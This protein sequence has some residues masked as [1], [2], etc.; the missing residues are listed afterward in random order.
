MLRCSSLVDSMVSCRNKCQVVQRKR[1]NRLANACAAHPQQVMHTASMDERML[2]A[3]ESQ[4]TILHQRWDAL[5]RVEPVNTPLGQPEA[6]THLIDFTL[7]TLFVALKSTHHPRRKQLKSV[8]DCVADH[9]LCPCGRNPLLAYFVAG[10][11]ALLETLIL[12]QADMPDRASTR[13]EDVQELKLVMAQ[14]AHR[15]IETF[16]ALCQHKDAHVRAGQESHRHAVPA[17]H[18]QHAHS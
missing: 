7:N 12:V 8:R 5:L 14:V 10:E 2:Q 16:C 6:L 18:G 17:Q 9:S 1:C 15:E 13:A 3:L 11:Q 4:R